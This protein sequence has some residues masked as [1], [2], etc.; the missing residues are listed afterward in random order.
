MSR[1]NAKKLLIAIIAVIVVVK[2]AK[3]IKKEK[4]K[5]EVSEDIF[6]DFYEEELNWWESE[7][8]EGEELQIWE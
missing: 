4:K 3:D 2:V 7:L 6:D 1:E 8:E 5:K